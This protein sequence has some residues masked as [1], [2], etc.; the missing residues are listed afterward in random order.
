MIMNIKV[1]DHI[2]ITVKDINKTM[3]FYGGLLN[4]KIDR[5]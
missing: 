1:I 2:V 5:R 4:M 3:D